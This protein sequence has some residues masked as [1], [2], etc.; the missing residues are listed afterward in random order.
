MLVGCIVCFTCVFV[1][2]VDGKFITNS[3]LTFFC[4]VSFFAI[5]CY[6]MLLTGPDLAGGRTGAQ[7]GR[8]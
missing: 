2:G 5:S 3:S 7:Q 8:C 6:V 4:H 1:N